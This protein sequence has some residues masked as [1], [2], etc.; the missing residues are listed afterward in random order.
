MILS[1]KGNNLLYDEMIKE[2][3]KLLDCLISYDRYIIV[4]RYINNKT[5]DSIAID[6]NY[7]SHSSISTKLE[8]IMKLLIKNNKSK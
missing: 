4:E 3:D 2:V 5:I 8:N 6:L 7:S 1:G